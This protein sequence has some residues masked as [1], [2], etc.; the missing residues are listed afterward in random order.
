VT[1][2]RKVEDWPR[3]MLDGS[4]VNCETTGAAGGGGVSFTGAGG[5][6]GGGGGAFFLQPAANIINNNA[7]PTNVMFRLLNM[8]Y[9]LQKSLL[10]FPHVG[11]SLWPLVVSCWTC[12]PSASMV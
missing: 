9:R 7:I 10:H 2:Q 11:R 1:S 4:A 6:G 8:K 5:G 3:W 12:V